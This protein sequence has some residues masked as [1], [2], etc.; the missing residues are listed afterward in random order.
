M[1]FKLIQSPDS[2][3]G[4]VLNICL[5]EAITELLIEKGIMTRDEV[6][7]R[8]AENEAMSVGE[9]YELVDSVAGSRKE[10]IK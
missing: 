7:K 10:K 1:S 4:Y 2:M 8:I 9:L 5:L 3:K 6:V